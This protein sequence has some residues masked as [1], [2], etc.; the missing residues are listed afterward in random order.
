M[1]KKQKRHKKKEEKPIQNTNTTAVQLSKKAMEWSRIAEEAN[2]AT[3]DASRAIEMICYHGDTKE[4][5]VVIKDAVHVLN[6]YNKQAIEKAQQLAILIS[7][8]PESPYCSVLAAEAAQFHR[9]AQTFS[10]EYA[11][12]ANTLVEKYRLAKTAALEL[13]SVALTASKTHCVAADAFESVAN[14]IEDTRF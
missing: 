3:D 9:E 2:R 8:D 5:L 10:M 1:S 7:T 4:E 13:I 14:K 12:T 6:Q 11:N